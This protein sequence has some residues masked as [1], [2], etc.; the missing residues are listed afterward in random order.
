VDETRFELVRQR[1]QRSAL[2]IG[3]IRPLKE[4]CQRVELCCPGL[5]P[6]AYATSANTSFAESKGFEPLHRI[7]DVLA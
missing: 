3:A 5:Q 2:P 7:N 1:L 4:M 6:V